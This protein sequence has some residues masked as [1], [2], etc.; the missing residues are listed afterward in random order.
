MTAVNIVDP[1]DAGLRFDPR[2]RVMR[3]VAVD[4]IR[5]P[6]S[7]LTAGSGQVTCV[8]EAF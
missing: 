3:S 1:V 2:T 8:S 6:V 5:A 7:R 4:A